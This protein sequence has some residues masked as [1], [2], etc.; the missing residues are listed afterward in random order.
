MWNGL[1]KVLEIQHR[2]K[3]GNIVW[4]QNNIRNVLHLRGE[5][6][7]LRAAFTGGKVSNVIP[8]NYYLGLD[9]RSDVVADNEMSDTSG[10]PAFSG[11]ERQPVASAGDFTVSLESGHYQ[12]ISPI[13]AFVA[14]GGAWGP[15]QNLFLSDQSGSLGTLIST[16]VLDTPVTVTDGESVTMRIAMTLKDCAP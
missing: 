6:F 7:L 13:V 2:D 16:A 8:E 10:E 12:A 5:E 3:N 14:V 15:V 11:Y 4:Q 1:M 9:N